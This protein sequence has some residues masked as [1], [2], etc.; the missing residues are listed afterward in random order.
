MKVSAQMSWLIAFMTVLACLSLLS[1]AL[2]RARPSNKKPEDVSSHMC[3]LTILK[4]SKNGTSGFKRETFSVD[5][6]VLQSPDTYCRGDSPILTVTGTNVN[7]YAD[8]AKKTRLAQGNTYHSPPL[9]QTTTFY[10]TQTL[11]SIESLP[12]AITIEM[13]EA[14]LVKIVTTPANCGKNDGT[15][16]ITATGATARNPLQYSINNGPLQT[17]PVFTN[18]SPGTY[19]VIDQI[20]KCYGTS[21]V[22]VS[23]QL[24]PTITRIDPVDPTCGLTNGSLTIM[25]SGGNGL[26][27]Y[28]LNGV[29]FKNDNRF[30]NLVGGAYMVTVRDQDLCTVSKPVSLNK[31]IPL[32][33]KEVDV[34]ATSC[35]Q[36]NGRIIL[37]STGGNGTITYTLDSSQVNASGIFENLLAKTYTV[38]VQDETGCHDSRQAI[39]G[40]SAGPKI[41]Q[42]RLASPTCGTQ[43]GYLTISASSQSSLLYS[44]NAKTYQSDSLF[45]KLS[46]GSYEVSIQ[47]SL[48][49]I[50][51]QLVTLDSPCQDGIYF[52]DSFT[53]N[54]DGIN[55]E[56]A[57]F[58]PFASLQL[59]DLTIINRWGEVVFH[60]DAR[61]VTNGDYLWNGK[62]KNEIQPGAYTYQLRIRFSLDKIYQYSG[63]IFLLR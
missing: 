29:D 31:T 8:A 13:V 55:D 2:C 11:S 20:A 42:I 57:I 24:V 19:T 53:P 63:T 40:S 52:P 56:W 51:K 49:C 9:N 50:T 12:I 27:S 10:L 60:S 1:E 5:S 32:Q 59:D 17:S 15:I 4:F 39:V 36:T 28:S 18:L 33:L 3:W 23:Q 37:R 38:S 47:D 35:G 45:T 26:L 21:Y 48:H 54:Q 16:S 22:V 14:Y 34:I 25:A 7:W 44:I 58:F 6:I 41:N 30:N 43:D 46:A 61:L 62:Y